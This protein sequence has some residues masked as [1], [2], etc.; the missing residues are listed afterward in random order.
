MP[1]PVVHGA[2]VDVYYGKSEENARPIISAARSASRRSEQPTNAFWSGGPPTR[3]LPPTW[4]E[5]G[6]LRHL[7]H[8]R[9]SAQN[10]SPDKAPKAGLPGHLFYDI[11]RRVLNQPAWFPWR[12]AVQPFL[13][14]HRIAGLE[15]G[16]YLLCRGR[17]CDELRRDVDPTRQF[18]WQQVPGA[19]LD[20]PLVL[21]RTGD[22][23]EEARL[24]SCVQDIASDSAFAVA[25]LAE[26]L[27]AMKLHGAWWYRRVHWEACA[28][29]G[30]LYLAAGAAKEEAGMLQSTG[31]GCF[32]APWV[33]ALLKVDAPNWADVYHFTLGWPDEDRRVDVKQPPYHHVDE[34]R[35]RNRDHVDSRGQ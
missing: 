21:L 18:L 22:F 7:I 2:P 10:Y 14:V 8:T 4:V 34:M 24:G 32:F 5:A 25:F 3:D 35:N 12:P 9:R 28:L 19:P 20:V 16:L 29:G 23:R 11:L 31:I 27:P 6:S 17:S 13:F 15:R 30:A 26:H 1:D 33:Q